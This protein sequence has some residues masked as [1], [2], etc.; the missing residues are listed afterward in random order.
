M[1]EKP[2]TWPQHRFHMRPEVT[3]EAEGAAARSVK[4][5]EAAVSSG[6]R[7]LLAI[8]LYAGLSEKETRAILLKRGYIF[9]HGQ[10]PTITA[11]T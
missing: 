9:G 2:K 3:L 7:T 5:I 8:R 4:L 10:N 1:L 11:K 6:K